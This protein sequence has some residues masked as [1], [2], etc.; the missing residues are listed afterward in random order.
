MNI[1]KNIDGETYQPDP[2]WK[3]VALAGSDNISVEYFEKPPHHSSPMHS[4]PQEQICIAISGR[5]R[6][7]NEN[8]EESVLQSGDSAWFAPNEPHRVENAGDSLAIGI[9]IFVP[10]RSFDF[11]MN[12]IK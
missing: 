11:W 1:V 12:K 6:V 5:I 2:G 10:A 3:R 7:I 9:D 4:H 8:D